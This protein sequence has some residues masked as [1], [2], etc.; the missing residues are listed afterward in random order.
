LKVT[1]PACCSP[2]HQVCVGMQWHAGFYKEEL[3]PTFR[4]FQSF[5][6]FYTG[7]EDYFT[8]N[9][10]G[11]DFRRDPSFRCGANCSQ[12]AWEDKG[13]YSTT[14]FAGEAVAVIQAHDTAAAPLFLYL[15]FQVRAR[16]RI[17]MPT[18]RSTGQSTYRQGQIT[19]TVQLSESEPALWLTP[20]S[21]ALTTNKL[22]MMRVPPD[23]CMTQAV[24]APPEVPQEYVPLYGSHIT[25]HKRANFAGMLGAMCVRSPCAAR[26]SV[27]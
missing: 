13:K 14:M 5:Y 3:T 10:G 23:V 4:G 1:H 24:H 11:Y 21:S 9:A 6:G 20:A 8:H 22:R 15:A 16:C 26:C 7:G 18:A 2:S 17:Y 12:V 27:R 19:L 25:D